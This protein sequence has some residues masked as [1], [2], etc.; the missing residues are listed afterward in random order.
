MLLTTTTDLLVGCE[1]DHSPPVDRSVALGNGWQLA[2][3]SELSK[4]AKSVGLVLPRCC[5]AGEDLV[6]L[7]DDVNSAPPPPRGCISMAE[8]LAAAIMEDEG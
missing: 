5:R 3:V 1:G 7:D 6:G 8:V 2:H 4:L